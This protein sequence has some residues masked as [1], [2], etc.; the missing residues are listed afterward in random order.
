MAMLAHAFLAVVRTDEHAR[1]P[2]SDELIPLPEV[3]GTNTAESPGIDMGP[4]SRA[5]SARQPARELVP[6]H[7]DRHDDEKGLCRIGALHSCARSCG[8][9]GGPRGAARQ[10]GAVSG[11]ARVSRCCRASGA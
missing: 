2:D 1:H 4:G 9:L 10:A 7:G 3:T 8:S 6:C 5:R 11:A